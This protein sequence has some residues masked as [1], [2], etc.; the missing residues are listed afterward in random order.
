MMQYSV[1]AYQDCIKIVLPK[2]QSAVD[3]ESFDKLDIFTDGFFGLKSIEKLKTRYNFY[4]VK[5]QSPKAITKV[6]QLFAAMCKVLTI[7]GLDLEKLKKFESI[8]DKIVN[9]EDVKL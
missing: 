7:K 6:S 8:I 5:S 3:Y 2:G 1:H 4:Y 9:G